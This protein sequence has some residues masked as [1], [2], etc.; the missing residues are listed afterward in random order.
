MELFRS[1]NSTQPRVL[2]LSDGTNSTL[3][4][5]SVHGLLVQNHLTYLPPL[6][7][8]TNSGAFLVFLFFFFLFV[9]I[10]M[11]IIVY[12]ILNSCLGWG[13]LISRK[14]H[15]VPNACCGILRF[16]CTW[17]NFDAFHRLVKSIYL[18]VT[19]PAL[20]IL[21]L[22]LYYSSGRSLVAEEMTKREK[23]N[24]VAPASKRMTSLMVPPWYAHRPCW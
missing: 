1:M 21:S 15:Y 5:P 14:C 12:S 18:I 8:H 4:F 22:F 3:P 10:T 2:L 6:R 16:I 24:L 9:S 20:C 17:V 19:A 11:Q 23:R 13:L 7:S